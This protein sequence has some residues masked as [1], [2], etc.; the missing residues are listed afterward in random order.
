M[1]AASHVNTAEVLCLLLVLAA[2]LCLLLGIVGLVGAF[3]SG[4]NPGAALVFGI[5][6]AVVALLLC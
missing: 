2:V 4:I 1:I 3:R 6:L 5:L